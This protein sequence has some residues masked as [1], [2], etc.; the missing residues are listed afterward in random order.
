MIPHLGARSVRVHTNDT[1]HTYQSKRL[2]TDPDTPVPR[3]ETEPANSR[4]L[5]TLARGFPRG[6]APA[7]ARARRRRRTG[8]RA[9]RTRRTV[10]PPRPRRSGTGHT[11]PR[12]RARASGARAPG[13][14]GAST[15][16]RRAPRSEE[17]TSELQSHS[18]LVC[19]LLLE[20]KKKTKNNTTHTTNTQAKDT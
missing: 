6:A 17:H 3:H 20:K 4:H 1:R 11:R 10:R 16:A 15:G 19:R 12:T 2:G 8:T 7:P 9:R 5:T 13:R 18:D 14:A